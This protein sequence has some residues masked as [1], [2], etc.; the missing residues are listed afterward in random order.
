MNPREKPQKI[1]SAEKEEL[2]LTLSLRHIEANDIGLKI[3]IAKKKGTNV[4]V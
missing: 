3:T 2:R 1:A 4:E